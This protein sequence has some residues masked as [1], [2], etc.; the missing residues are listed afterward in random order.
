MT[1][2][3]DFYKIGNFSSTK[4]SLKLKLNNDVC[5]IVRNIVCCL[6]LS[7]LTFDFVGFNFPVWYT[8]FHYSWSIKGNSKDLQ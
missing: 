4:H 5:C 1:L 6:Q 7:T 2:V 3:G 8:R